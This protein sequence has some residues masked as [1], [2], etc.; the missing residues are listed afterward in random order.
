MW[1]RSTVCYAAWEVGGGVPVHRLT[2]VKVDGADVRVADAGAAHDVLLDK[3]LPHRGIGVVVQVS[4]TRHP[5]A[6]CQ[7]NHT[8]GVGCG[9]PA[10]F[11]EIKFYKNALKFTLI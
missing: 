1:P 5:A 4:P 2:V 11:L 10:N 3:P 8:M 6:V 7:R 9:S